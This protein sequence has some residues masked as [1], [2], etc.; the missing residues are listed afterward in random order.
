MVFAG[1]GATANEFNYDD[2]SGVDVKDKIVVLLRYEPTGFAA[3]GGNQGLTRYAAPMLSGE[4]CVMSG[5]P[6]CQQ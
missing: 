3:K 5:C 1:Y 2:F 4:T 6:H